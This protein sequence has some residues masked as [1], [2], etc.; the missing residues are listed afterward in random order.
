MT[1]RT[2]RTGAPQGRP[3]VALSAILLGWIIVRMLALSA[4]PI[5]P[6]LPA[7]SDHV[8]GI[9]IRVKPPGA[10]TIQGSGPVRAGRAERAVAPAID[11]A[12]GA[13]FVPSDESPVERA[14]APAPVPFVAPQATPSRPAMS[15]VQMAATHQMLWMAALA[16][17]PL[18]MAVLRR[19]E[20]A[21]PAQTAPAYPAGREQADG[22][23]WSVDGWVLW[24]RGSAAGLAGGAAP[25]TYGGSQLG[26]VARYRLVPASSHLPAL[27][28]RATAP[29]QGAGK[30]VAL[31]LSARPLGGLPVIAAAEMRVTQAGGKARARPAAMVVSE[32]PAF[33]LPGKS[34]GEAYVQ[35]GYVGGRNATAFVDGQL[36]ADRKVASVGGIELRA[37]GGVWGGAQKGAARLDVGPAASAAVGLGAGGAAR[38]ALDW[39]LRVAGDSAP[40]SGPALTLSAGF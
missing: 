23:R 33:A 22:R 13:E 3:V 39:R 19:M 11:P 36:R 9:A 31:G 38:L 28:L 12:P 20:P 24:R 32:L 35:A 6:V 30:E 14:G 27:F 8:A 15:N 7:R 17:V 25:S 34:R 4:Y 18:P 21:T 29:L 10:A 1:G 5:L 16:Q 2:I 37:G 26:A 40:R